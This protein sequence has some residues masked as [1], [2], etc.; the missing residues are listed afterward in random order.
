MPKLFG[1]RPLGDADEHADHAPEL[2]HGPLGEQVGWKEGGGQR[3]IRL[4]RCDNLLGWGRLA[5]VELGPAPNLAHRR[6]SLQMRRAHHRG[7]VKPEGPPPEFGVFD[8]RPRHLAASDALANAYGQG[9][10]S[11]LLGRLVP[12]MSLD[13]A[14]G[15]QGSGRAIGP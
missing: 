12:K 8:Q 7:P 5:G 6:F 1:V 10:Q 15:C 13:H 14:R 4:H 3:Q 9:P 2:P 11:R